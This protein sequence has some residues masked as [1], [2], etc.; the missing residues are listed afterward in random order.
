[1]V[2][3]RLLMCCERFKIIERIVGLI[4]SNVIVAGVNSKLVR[5]RKGTMRMHSLGLFTRILTI[6]LS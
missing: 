6:S 3:V 5:K 2:E 1:M 4:F